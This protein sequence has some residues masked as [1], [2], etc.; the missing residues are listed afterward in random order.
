MKKRHGSE[1]EGRTG[2]QGIVRLSI[3]LTR[4]QVRRL[5]AIAA[6][7]ER[8]RSRIARKAVA[9]L[10]ACEEREQLEQGAEAP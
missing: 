1:I 10:L 7:E 5:D 6:R 9:M 2:M 4:D 3:G 8:S